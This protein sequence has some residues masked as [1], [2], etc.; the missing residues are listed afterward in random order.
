MKR[1]LSLPRRAAS[2]WAALPA[3]RRLRL[4]VVAA[5]V[6]AVVVGGGIGVRVLTAAEPHRVTAYFESSV[7]LY[8]G[9]DV[10]ILGVKV[11]E[12]TSVR[13][14]GEHVVVELEFDPEVAVAADT[15]AVLVSPTMVADRYV[16]LTEPWTGGPQLAD[17]AVIP[18]ERTAVPVEID[19]LYQSLDEVA[20]LL[21]PEG[22]NRDGAL[23]ALIK[24]GAANLDGNGDG[25]RRLLTDLGA[26]T[27][28]LSDTGADTFATVEHLDALA[29]VLETN[30]AHVSEVNGQLARIARAIAGD[31]ETMAAA[32]R[33]LVVALD[34]VETFVRDSRGQ[35]ATSLKE[36]NAA[37]EVLARHKAALGV[38]LGALPG[39]VQGLL[40][41]YD[42]QH[43][44]LVGRGN[45]NDV[46]LGGQPPLGGVTEHAPPA[47]PFPMPGGAG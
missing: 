35:V 4:L 23:S 24:T 9:S 29:K 26:A 28:T 40:G 6:V 43:G 47:L 16:Q 37:T 17:G 46:T 22:V 12:V 39:A 21:G 3:R 15:R 11:G 38:V 2:R 20:E 8:K 44:V 41:A 1:L 31:R 45:P 27:R 34:D 19:R 33:E 14:T 18:Q 25:I 5:A 42:S 36:L 30:D 13:P 32:M 7:G 10:R